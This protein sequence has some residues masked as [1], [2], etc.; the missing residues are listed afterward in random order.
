MTSVAELL[1]SDERV[2]W[3]GKPKLTPFVFGHSPFL[4]LFGLFFIAVALIFFVPFL[5]LPGFPFEF[6][7]FFL[8]FFLIGF[9]AAFGMPIWSFLA[10][11]NTEYVITNQRLITQTGAVGLDTRFVD[12]EKIQEVNVSIGLTDRLL[13]TGS[14]YVST[15]GQAFV[16][17]QQQAYGWT[18]QGIARPSLANLEKPY[19]VQKLLQEAIQDVRRPRF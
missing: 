6:V 9:V 8:V 3:Q 12:L 7:L 16:G 2:L 13:G 15:A 10:F 17:W 18:G 14:I 4:F 11:R 5:S 19:E 1:R